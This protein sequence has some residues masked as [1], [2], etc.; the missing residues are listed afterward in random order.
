MPPPQAEAFVAQ[1]MKAT[2]ITVPCSHASLVPHPKAIAELTERAAKGAV[3]LQQKLR[4]SRHSPLRI[5]P[6][7]LRVSFSLA[8]EG[9][10]GADG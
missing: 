5:H 7:R 2:T 8:G 9:V 4:S 6:S 3:I 10:G 1:R